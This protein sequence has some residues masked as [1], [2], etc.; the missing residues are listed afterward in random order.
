MNLKQRRKNQKPIIRP[1]ETPQVKRSLPGPAPYPTPL[2]PVVPCEGIVEV[3]ELIDYPIAKRAY[4]WSHE[5]DKLG[6]RKFIVVLHKEPIS[7]P[8]KAVMAYIVNEFKNKET[9]NHEE[10]NGPSKAH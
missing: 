3:F 2:C 4:I 5:S 7:S 9:S 10:K 6:K 1:P 8:K